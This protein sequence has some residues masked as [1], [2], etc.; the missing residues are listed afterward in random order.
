MA[1][2]APNKR[3]TAGQSGS[4]TADN[5][6]QDPRETAPRDVPQDDAGRA[7]AEARV[8]ALETELAQ[9]RALA[10]DANAVRPPRPSHTQHFACGCQ[11]ETASPVATQRD[12]AEHKGTF[13][14]LMTIPIQR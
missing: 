8:R 9:M 3:T 7:A 4:G 11:E 2:T 13:P 12:C 6:G 1:T 5:E 10:G 14:V